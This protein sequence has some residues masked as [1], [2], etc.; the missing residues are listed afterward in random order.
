MRDR[1]IDFFIVGA[2]KCGTTSLYHYLRDLGTAVS[3]PLT[4]EVLVFSDDVKFSDLAAHLENAYDGWVDGRI[5]GLA[6][7]RLLYYF[8]KCSGRLHDHNPYAKIVTV[9]RN[10]VERAHSAYW[11][12]RRRGVEAAGSFEE[13]VSREVGSILDWDDAIKMRELSYLYTGMYSRQVKAFVSKFGRDN[14]K[15]ILFE[16]FFENV[17]DGLGD[18]CAFLGVRGRLDGLGLAKKYN[19]SG[20]SRLKGLTKLQ[21]RERIFSKAYHALLPTRVRL[22]LRERIV[23]KLIAWNVKPEVNPVMSERTRDFLRGFYRQDVN[24]LSELIGVDLEGLWLA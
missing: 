6:D 10:P 22:V 4:K 12:A 18:L 11:F 5:V 3:L 9:L 24:L 2:Q 1:K 13:A 23:D 15:I 7:V 21:D 14:V 17:V 20:R 16:S 8:E 19:V